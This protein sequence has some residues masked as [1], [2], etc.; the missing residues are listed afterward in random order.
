MKVEIPSNHYG[1]MNTAEFNNNGNKFATGGIDGIINLSSSEKI[2]KKGKNLGPEIKLIK[3]GHN[4][5]ILDL[6]FSHPF[7]GNY[8]ASCGHDKKLIIWKEKSINDYENIYEYKHFSPVKCCKF[9]PYQYGLILICGTINGDITIHQL[10]KNYQK[11]NYHLLKNIHKDG[12]NSI[13]WAPSSPPINIFFVDDE[14]KYN[15]LEEDKEN[16]DTEDYFEHLEPMRFICCGNDRKIRI[17]ISKKNTIDSFYEEKEFNLES[18]PNDVSFLNF[19]GYTQLIFACGLDNG[20]CL[21][22]KHSNGEWKKS[23]EIS[24]GGD[25]YKIKWSLCGTYLGIS[26][27]QNEKDNIIKFY[28]ENMDES[29]IEVV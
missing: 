1:T 23:F 3:N 4:K 27:K 11:W 15:P 7:Y 2:F 10:Q 16:L 19:V 14:E 26:S 6:S 22:Y 9:A 20:K 25:I 8:I 24:V 13:D 28:R 12:I 29:W 21:I 17:F 18:I 5:S